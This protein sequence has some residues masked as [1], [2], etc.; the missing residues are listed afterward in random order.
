VAVFILPLSKLLGLLL[1]WAIP[2]V[3]FLRVPLF[4]LYK[5]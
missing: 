4:K 2:L 5:R 1:F 3:T